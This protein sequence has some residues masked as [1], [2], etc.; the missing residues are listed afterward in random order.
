M[1]S[2][3]NRRWWRIATIF[4]FSLLWNLLNSRNSNNVSDDGISSSSTMIGNNHNYSIHDPYPTEYCAT[5]GSLHQLA[6]DMFHHSSPKDSPSYNKLKHVISMNPKFCINL[7]GGNG[8]FTKVEE[9]VR[10]CYMGMGY[11][12]NYLKIAEA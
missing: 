1:G 12:Q 11:S 3:G 5:Y 10:I 8:I 4:A 2:L 6:L 9:I 7:G